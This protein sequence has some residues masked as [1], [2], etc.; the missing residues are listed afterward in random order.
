MKK[1]LLGIAAIAALIGTPALAA[2]MALKAPPPP[3]AQVFSWT[4]FY[5]GAQGG[6][7]GGSSSGSETAFYFCP[8]GGA[9]AA[10]TA[11][12]PAIPLNQTSIG[13]GFGGVTAGYNWQIDHVVLGV[14]GDWSGADINGSGSCS[15][16]FIAAAFAGTSGNCGTNLRDFATVTGRIGWAFDRALLYVKGGGAWGQFNYSAT[17]VVAG[18]PG[19]AA[20]FSD[21]RSGYTVGVGLELAFSPNWSVKVEYQHMG[22]GTNN[23]TYPFANVPPFAPGIFNVVSS[24]SERVDIIRAGV[25]YRFNWGS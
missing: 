17:S 12:S 21:D 25:N 3:P 1:T 7:G 10:Q 6:G 18:I 14:E 13:G 8:T 16:A 5:I 4:G 15:T 9:C 23:I 2:D 11:V 19:P 24:D 20:N 22:F